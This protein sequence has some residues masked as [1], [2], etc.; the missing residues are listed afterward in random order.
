MTFREQ[1]PGGDIAVAKIRAQ[2]MKAR[3]LTGPAL[4]HLDYV[5]QISKARV[6]DGPC[7]RGPM[8]TVVARSHSEVVKD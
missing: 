1:I 5:A 7:R 2:S 3:N 4:R 6:Y 8:I